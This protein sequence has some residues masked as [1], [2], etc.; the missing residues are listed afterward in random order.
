MTV[1]PHGDVAAQVVSRLLAAGCVFAEDEA[2]L[3]ISE[4]R[5]SA[6]L[7]AMV[8]RRVDGEPLEY[9]LGW[10]EFCDRRIS[11]DPGVFVPRNR[12]EFLVREA[13]D[14]VAPPVTVV[15]L[16]CGSGAVGVALV[17][18][19]GDVELHAVDIDPA[20]VRCAR[21]NV[22][23]VGGRVYEGDL[24]EP[25][26]GALRG[27]IDVMAVNAPY[28]PTDAIG[29]LAREARLYEPRIALDG[30]ADGLNVVRR[31]A[32]EA[33]PWLAPGGHLLVETSEDQAPQVVALFADN[34]LVAHSASC[35]DPN[36]TVVIGTKPAATGV[37]HR[38]GSR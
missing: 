2:R 12:T 11:V 34:G 10:A 8:N 23:T 26:P 20:A 5:T 24:C 22:A 7:A 21:R 3:L 1:L 9:V 15:D 16:C 4:A 36:A 25:L 30:G 17:A 37:H 13:A 27:R 14:L 38:L 33:P 35:D 6:H 32:S 31:V 29:M 28:V 19:L 18:A